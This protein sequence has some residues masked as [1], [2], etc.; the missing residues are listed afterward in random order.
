MPVLKGKIRSCG[1][2]LELSDNLKKTRKFM[3]NEYFLPKHIF[4]GFHKNMG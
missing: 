3:Q 4:G 2:A 1:K